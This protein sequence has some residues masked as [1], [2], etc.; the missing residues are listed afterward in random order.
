MYEKY[1][2]DKRAYDQN[3][4]DSQVTIPNPSESITFNNSILFKTIEDIDSMTDVE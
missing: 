3:K 1:W 4:Q 2:E